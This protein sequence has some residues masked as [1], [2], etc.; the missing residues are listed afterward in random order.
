MKWSFAPFVL[1]LGAS[2][3]A[4]QPTKTQE[5]IDSQSSS[6]TPAP[7]VSYILAGRLFDAA[8]DQ[9]RETMVIVVEGE[10]IKA[11]SAAA[12]IRI[13]QGANVV[14]LSRST[15]L[16]GL[17]DCHTHMEARADRYNE[18]YKFKRFA[19]HRS[20]LRCRKCA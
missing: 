2:C 9:T 4:Q 10:R 1:L 15:V 7:K 16:P 11:V 3:F 5:V 17:I 13:P 12:Q 19:L 20:L 18:I 8:S 6:G 14:D